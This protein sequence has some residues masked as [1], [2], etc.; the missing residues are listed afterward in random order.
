MEGRP[1]VREASLVQF[2]TKPDFAKEMVKYYFE[3]L[4]NFQCSFLRKKGPSIS[5]YDCCGACSC[6]SST[7]SLLS[8]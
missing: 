4:F 3:A 2:R 7:R 1:L 6:L 8:Y 5:V